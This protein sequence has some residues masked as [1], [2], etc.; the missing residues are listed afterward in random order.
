MIS[1]AT[2]NTIQQENRKFYSLSHNAAVN[3]QT[4]MQAVE[5]HNS[6]LEKHPASEY[7][8]DLIKEAISI[9]D[10]QYLNEHRN[11][12]LSPEM[13]FWGKEV[14]TLFLDIIISV[15]MACVFGLITWLRL[16]YYFQ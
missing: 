5:S 6:F 13:E 15:L 3:Y 14:S 9:A 4:Y 8:N 2:L 7:S 1:S 10:G 12:F 16:H 11:I